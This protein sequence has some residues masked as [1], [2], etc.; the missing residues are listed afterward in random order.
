LDIPQGSMKTGESVFGLVDGNN[1]YC[2]C[3]R[4]FNPKLANVPLVVLSNNDGCAIARSQEAKA[5]GIRMGDPFFLIR[6]RVKANNVRVFSSNY[7]LYGDMSRRVLTT[8]QEFT[9]HIEAYSI[10]ESFLDLSG[11]ADKNLAAYGQEIRATVRQWTGIPTCVGIGPT[12][13]LAKLANWT[14]KHH[15]E[16][17]GVCDLTDSQERETILP[18]VPVEAVWGIGRASV[19]KLAKL[20]V[21]TVAQLRE[22]DPRAVRQSLTVVGERIIQELRGVSCLNLEEIEP[23][24]KGMA[25]TRSFGH[26]VTEK[27][28]MLEAVAAHTTRVAEKLRATGLAAVGMIVFAH[29]NRHNADPSYYG[30]AVCE[31]YEATDDTPELLGLAVQGVNRLWRDGFRYKKCGVIL[32]DLVRKDERQR[33]F[34]ALADA[35]QAKRSRLMETIDAINQKWGRGTIFP[36]AAGIERNWKIRSEMKSPCFTTRFADLP[37]ARH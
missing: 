12:K 33:S 18:A 34:F 4:V 9:P 31:P 16:M 17:G 35:D 36:A 29:T 10:D 20:G 2:S 19:A 15:P 28:E 30:S 22:A 11:F 23:Q 24:R 21:R 6:D 37:Q 27:T 32:P 1:F 5:L 8:L 13:T 25:V 7:T 26:A 3:E 14:A